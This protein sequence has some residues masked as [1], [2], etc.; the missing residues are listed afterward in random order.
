MSAVP[1]KDSTATRT[2]RPASV[3]RPHTSQA[4]VPP[5]SRLALGM[6]ARTLRGARVTQQSGQHVRRLAPRPRLVAAVRID[7]DAVARRELGGDLAAPDAVAGD[8]GDHL[9]PDMQRLAEA[10]G[11]PWGAVAGAVVDRDL[12][13]APAADGRQQH[14]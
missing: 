13:D 4:G 9:Q 6:L 8:E 2:A 14:H 5:S 10:V 11:R 12:D 1:S 3:T 7:P